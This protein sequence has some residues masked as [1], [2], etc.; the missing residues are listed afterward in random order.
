MSRRRPFH[1]SEPGG[2]LSGSLSRRD[3]IRPLD[4]PRRRVQMPQRDEEPGDQPLEVPIR[5]DEAVPKDPSQGD[6]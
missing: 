4:V 6:A 2:T 5:D 1:R 3:Y